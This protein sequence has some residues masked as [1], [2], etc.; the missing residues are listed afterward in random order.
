LGLV[1]WL[2]VIFTAIF[3][4]TQESKSSR[5]MEGFNDMAPQF[6]KVHRDGKAFA[7]NARELVVGDIV[8]IQAGDKIPADLLLIHANE[9]KVTICPILSDNL[10]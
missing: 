2:V 3:S 5:A 9:L 7:I 8:E 10:G 4:F 1:L 6:C